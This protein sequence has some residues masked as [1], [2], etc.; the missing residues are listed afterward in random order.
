MPSLADLGWN[1]Q[2]SAALPSDAALGRVSRVD[3][4]IA[5]VLTP[6]GAVRVRIP[7]RLLATQDTDQI[8][9]VGD[10]VLLHDEEID[11][12]LDRMSAVTRKVAGERTRAQVVAANVD[13]VF[14]V[15]DASAPPKGR[16]IER[17]LA[18]AWECGALPVVL[19]N[20]ADA[21]PE[22]D[23]AVEHAH[24]VALGVDVHA[25]SARTGEGL[26][27]LT[28]H[29]APGHTVVLIGPSGV[30]KSSL[31]N[32]FRGEDCVYTQDVRSDG[33]GRHTTSYREL[34]RL[35]S[36]ALLIDTPGLR[37]VGLWANEEGLERA[38]ADIVELETQ[39]QF[40]DCA[41]RTE[42]GCAV[43]AAIGAGDLDPARF[44]SWV[45]LQREVARVQDRR[46]GWERA[47]AGAQLRARQRSY[48]VARDIQRQRRPR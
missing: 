7:N 3:R 44:A 34:H 35:P 6:G 11:R 19:L 20:K 47:R 38:Y 10:W 1:P 12:V 9:T 30:G 40:R 27:L 45:K 31:V 15:D 37:E 21:T 18:L 5:S 29:L 22:S 41:H 8:P 4:G 42:P 46:A 33:K 16:R 43:A 26:E 39:C 24:A 48:K 23:S 32:A 25:V 14:V 13:V 2:R 36:G 28:K 17:Y